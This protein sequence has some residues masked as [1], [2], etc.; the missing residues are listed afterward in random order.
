MIRRSAKRGERRAA[1]ARMKAKARVLR[2]LDPKAKAAN[3]LQSC[4]CAMC[5]NQ[6]HWFG[7]TVQERRAMQRD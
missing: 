7:P 2:P 1:L 4:S 6:R 3:H 5:G